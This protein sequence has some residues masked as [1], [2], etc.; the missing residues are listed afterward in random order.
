MSPKAYHLS[1]IAL[2]IIMA[3]ACVLALGACGGSQ[4]TILEP[5]HESFRATAEVEAKL[6]LGVATIHLQADAYLDPPVEASVCAAATVTALSVLRGKAWICWEI[7][8]VSTYHLCG[9]ILG[10]SR[11]IDG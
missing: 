3:L 5:D 1:C 2:A 6:D 11:C 9:E 8:P 10:I 7:L 4:E